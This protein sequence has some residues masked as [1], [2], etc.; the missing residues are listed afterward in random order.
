MSSTAVEYPGLSL[1]P[2]AWL[3]PAAGL[4]MGSAPSGASTEMSTG[5]TLVAVEYAGGVVLGA[6]SRTS[7]GTYVANRTTDKLTPVTE[8]ILACRSGSAA[9]TQAV[10]DVVKY[11]L[12]FLEIES[13][14]PAPVH[15]AAFLFKDICYEYRDSLTAGIIVAGWDEKKGGQVYSIP[16]GGMMVRQGA[17]IGGSGSSYI[18]GYMDANYKPNMTREEALDLVSRC[19]TLAINRD[20]SSGGCCFMA[21]VDKNGVERKTILHTD[22]PTF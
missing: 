15:T 1:A 16:L 11:K 22:L 18:Y 10:T 7:M 9:D 14:R 21:A 13:G 4:G 12:A 2:P 6:D 20:G 19:V 17:T 8:R 3:K 5:T